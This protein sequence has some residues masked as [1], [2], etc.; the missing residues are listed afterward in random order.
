MSG[1]ALPLTLLACSLSL[2]SPSVIT[3]A[4]PLR[5]T[6]DPSTTWSVNGYD[7]VQRVFGGT[8]N[9]T[10]RD[11]MSD[12]IK[13]MNLSAARAFLWPLMYWT[14]PAGIVSAPHTPWAASQYGGKPL[15]REEA[16]AGW[17]KYFAQDFDTAI[18]TWWDKA[19]P[20]N[21]MTYQLSLFEKWG[22][23]DGI[24]VHTQVD[25]S[26]DRSPDG[27]YNYYRAYL[28]TIKK[29][30]PNLNIQ[31]VQLTNEPNYP[32]WS[33]QFATTKESVDTWLRVFNR[34]D[35]HLNQT[36]PST[37]LLGP[38]LASSEFFSWGGW[39]NWTVPVLGGVERPMHYYN[40]H[41]YDSP[42]Y[43]NLAWL[44]MMHAK[45]DALKRPRPQGIVTEMQ[46]R[47]YNGSPDAWRERSHWWA[48]HFFTAL[49]HPD[50]VYELDNFMLAYTSK[51]DVF[52]ATNK[53]YQ[54]SDLYWVYWTLANTRGRSLYTGA[55][56]TGA[57]RVYASQPSPTKVVVS[58][59]NSGTNPVTLDVNPGLPSGSAV[60]DVSRRFA[61]YD[62]DK[63]KHGQVALATGASPA[64]VTLAPGGVSAIAWT[65]AKPLSAPW[66]T[67][68]EREVFS[69]T[70]ATPF[71]KDLAVSIPL[72]K[73]LAANETVALRFAVNTDD[74]LAARGLNVDFN[75]H[76]MPVYWNQA[77]HQT[78]AD[79][80]S[81]WWIELPL[82]AAWVKT[83]NKVTFTKP[84]ASYR[85]MFASLAVRQHPDAASA[86]RAE[87]EA[88]AKRLG[89]V[90]ASLKPIGSVVEHTSKP[91]EVLLDNQLST[92]A[93]YNVAVTLP[94]QV[95]LTGCAAQQT[96]S[97]PAHTSRAVRG[98]LTAGTVTKVANGAVSV[99]VTPTGGGGQTLTAPVDL[100]PMRTAVHVDASPKIDGDLSE[101][102]S[103]PPVIYT[104]N[105][106]TAKTK[107]AWD[108][109]NLYVVME[110]QGRFRPQRPDSVPNFWA[111]D[112]IELFIDLGNNKSVQ[113]DSDDHQL[114]LC[115][116][117]VDSDNAFGGRA[118]R[119]R[120]GD[121]VK[122][123]DIAA[124]A[125]FR[126]ASRI[127]DT[128]YVIEAAFPWSSLS[129]TF[130]PKAGL[131]IG[132]DVAVDH[133]K[134]RD[135]VNINDSVFGLPVKAF[136]SPDKWGVVTLLAPGSTPPTPSPIVAEGPVV[137][138]A[139][140]K[141]IVFSADSTDGWA[142]PPAAKIDSR[143][144]HLANPG[145]GSN[146][147]LRDAIPAPTGAGGVSTTITLAG[148][149]KLP[150][151]DGTPAQAGFRTHMRAYWTPKLP[152]GF[153]DP[154]QLSDT[155]W[156][157]GHATDDGLQL[158]LWR[159]VAAGEGNGTMLWSGAVAPTKYPVTMKLWMDGTDYQLT[160]E[161][162]LETAT[163]SRSGKHGLPADTWA[164]PVRFG[165]KSCY[166]T[167]PADMIISKVTV[168]PG[169]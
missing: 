98:V 87:S 53:Q 110:A 126:T 59:F 18:P 72:A 164:Q 105:G 101:W 68:G 23:T 6:V 157:M 11:Q 66:K 84:D 28:N 7:K 113:Y 130:R 64:N 108:A 33:G 77:P 95:T 73:A 152:T 13:A 99:T 165:V 102:A 162:P 167:Q 161:S 123:V 145:G 56:D 147:L 19:Y 71:D 42:A 5:V 43:T 140:P 139:A 74:L 143:G 12:E 81:T 155:L 138:L 67:L 4:A 46:Y 117:S 156:L 27:V 32:W 153:I 135:G 10:N 144:L 106:F 70:V 141:Q 159:K 150:V 158:S 100:F 35:T 52:V 63:L 168:Q 88:L 142:Y 85:L 116:V 24:I 55:T 62:G 40:Y 31:F 21:D 34:L 38:C 2:L 128:G 112:A 122:I 131:Q 30:H 96:V 129:P 9:G 1:P 133:S 94:A 78:D 83:V 149:E 120:K 58:L 57:V 109:T 82:K 61:E 79:T 89:G 44:S 80:R 163:G 37:Q 69:A 91:F 124:D 8:V 86:S 75:G 118:R 25:G 29:R 22:L 166:G 111:K 115:P 16:F 76:A 3:H 169:K 48:E 26:A 137:A 93:T 136:M 103:I 160:S 154:W 132:C 134:N 14:P 39:R 49:A 45:A 50:K 121:D 65:L 114:F 51:S 41:L 148:F 92:P 107:L 20:G 47:L 36:M 90:F 60:T 127:S 54:P 15:T 119:E 97:V 146:L 17:D 151:P 104:T 125:S